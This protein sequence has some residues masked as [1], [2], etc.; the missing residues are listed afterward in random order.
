MRLIRLI[1]ITVAL[2][3]FLAVPS[4][5]SASSPYSTYVACGYKTSAPAATKCSKHGRIGAFFKS[6]DATVRFKTC[7]TFPDGQ[8]MCTARSRATMGVYYVNKLHVGSRGTLTVSWKVHHKV[9][10]TYSIRVTR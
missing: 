8:H 3:V 9:V 4:M 5:A 1:A 6:K 10:A 7:V 2:G